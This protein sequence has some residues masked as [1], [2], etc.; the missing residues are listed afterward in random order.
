MTIC[1]LPWFSLLIVSSGRCHNCCWQDPEIPLGN[2][3]LQTCDEI[4][5]GD[6]AKQIRSSWLAGEIPEACKTGIG[7]CTHLGRR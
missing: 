5:N 7:C 1:E 3:S 6:T 4:W 2:I